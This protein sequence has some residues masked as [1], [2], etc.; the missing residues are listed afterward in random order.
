MTKGKILDFYG[1]FNDGRSMSLYDSRLNKSFPIVGFWKSDLPRCD[2]L[3]VY[4][5]LV[6]CLPYESQLMLFNVCGCYA[7]INLDFRLT[8]QRKNYVA[9]KIDV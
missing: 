2:G 7:D 8:A 1:K 5:I 3:E 9:G 4:Q 6:R